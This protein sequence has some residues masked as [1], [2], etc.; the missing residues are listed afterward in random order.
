M[1]RPEP[2]GPRAMA[3]L[4]LAGFFSAAAFRICDP[5]LPQLATEFATTTGAAAYTITVF[6]VA[7]G[8]LQIVWGPL[9]DHFGKFRMAGIAT[10]ACAVGNIGAVF[11]DSLTALIV[12]RFIAGATGGGIVPLALAWIGDTVLYAHRQAALARFLTSTILG[13]A[14]GQ[15]IGG[16]IADTLGWRWAFGLLACGYIASGILMQL[17]SG[18]AKAPAAGPH[19]ARDALPRPPFRAQVAA[20][21]RDRW[22]RVV[23][24][25]VALEGGIFTGALTF[26]PAALHD[27]FGLSLTAAGATA[28]A[29]GL[30]AVAYTL[31]ARRLVARLGERGLAQGGAVVML[32]A[33]AGLWLAP[34]WQMALAA[35]LLAGFGFYML[36]NT[37]QTNATQMAPDMRGTSLAL[38]ASCLFIGQSAGVALAALVVD[39]S[40]PGALFMGAM[41]LLPLVAMGFARALRTRPAH[42]FS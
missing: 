27:R 30:G 19:A 9:G 36:H 34:G 14:C 6:A 22:V 12:C 32:L 28:A 24:V 26:V 16:L 31:A 4:A 10:L 42:H 1:T 25:T 23:L 39:H 11:A 2:T 17:E 38:F 33:F 35:C 8:M 29:Y 13:V 21:L 7:Y 15:F 18:R 37:L 3:V 41:I 5:L 20:L 40:G